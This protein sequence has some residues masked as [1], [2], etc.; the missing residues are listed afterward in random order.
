MLRAKVP[1]SIRMLFSRS[2]STGQVMLLAAISLGGVI[3]GATTIAGTLMMYQIRHATDL[4]NSARAIFAADAGVE[5]ALEDSFQSNGCG[6]PSLTLSNGASYRYTTSNVPPPDSAVGW[7]MFDEGAGSTVADS[8]GN[9]NDA[10]WNG[11]G[12]HWD[13]G[14]IGAY[15]GQFNGT[16]D[17]VAARG[18]IG[19]LE[20][21]QAV[22]VAA[23][24][25]P[26]DL[27]GKRA[28][29][30]KGINDSG[31]FLRLNGGLLESFAA[32]NS[33]FAGS[34][35]LDSW[36]FVAMTYDGSSLTNYVDGQAVKV[37]S[38]GG[39]MDPTDTDLLIGSRGTGENPLNNVD[40]KF[41]GLIDDVR[42]YNTAL[43]DRD[44][45]NL[46][47]GSAPAMTILSEGTAGPA[48]RAFLLSL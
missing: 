19:I 22:T 45:L 11:G 29:V 43:S 16:D 30:Q 34:A 2:C 47:I 35:P 31:Y 44:I 42:V 8:S 48:S 32:G 33:L 18:N 37:I 23:W 9:V 40:E 17:Y 14:K 7:W 6:A 28:I 27:S 21:T 12:W 15:A 26:A 24:V 36:T 25:R 3:L 13:T 5:C 41:S 46:Y 10:A 39:A 20:P 38:A 1:K 4:E